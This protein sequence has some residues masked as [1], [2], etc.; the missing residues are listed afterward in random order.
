M[1]SGATRKRSS[2]IDSVRPTRL[3]R[4]CHAFRR[5]RRSSVFRSMLI[6][7]H[8]IPNPKSCGSWAH[9]ECSG[10]DDPAAYICAFCLDS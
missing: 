2:N 7:F 9:Q 6:L 5:E 3:T 1:R 10:S 4:Q 8:D